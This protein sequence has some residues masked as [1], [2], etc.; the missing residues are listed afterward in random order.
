MKQ[1]LS[2]ENILKKALKILIR[3]FTTNEELFVKRSMNTHMT[4]IVLIIFIM[5]PRN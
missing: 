5:K 2:S 3:Y 4:H 1:R